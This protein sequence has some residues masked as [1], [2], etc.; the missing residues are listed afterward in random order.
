MVDIEQ[1]L[2]EAV[3]SHPPFWTQNGPRVKELLS[4]AKDVAD[5][6]LKCSALSLVLPGFAV[7]LYLDRIG[8]NAIFLDALASTAGLM[9]LLAGTLLLISALLFLLCAPSLF[10]LGYGLQARGEK[11]IPKW[12]STLFLVTGLVWFVLVF[13]TSYKYRDFPLIL[14]VVITALVSFSLS[15][16][17]FQW[18]GKLHKLWLQH[19]L[20]AAL[21]AGVSTVTAVFT[22]IPFLTF[23]SFLAT[24]ETDQHVLR[25]TVVLVSICLIGYLPGIMGLASLQRNVSVL[26][27]ARFTGVGTACALYVL[28]SWSAVFST[29]ISSRVLERAGI[30]ST[31]LSTFEIRNAEVR[32]TLARAGM[33]AIDRQPYLVAAYMRFSFGDVRLLC[34]SSFTPG[35]T[36]APKDILASD[37]KSRQKSLD[38]ARNAGRDCV[39][40]KKDEL[41]LL[42]L[43]TGR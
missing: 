13:A 37:A 42:A 25:A 33:K 35:R 17:T 14:I 7:W 38:I 9:T 15:C 21:L 5:L 28:L 22:S 34:A 12:A 1:T 3:A 32:E 24:V 2:R 20:R 43:A 10:M 31:E 6:F 27:A 40:L 4:I 11:M 26:R 36:D 16:A 18:R 23:E 30:V 8:W 19:G 39:V 29:G 41:R